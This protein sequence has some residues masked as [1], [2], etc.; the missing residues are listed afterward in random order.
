MSPLKHPLPTERPYKQVQRKSQSNESACLSSY[1]EILISETPEAAN[2]I[3]E[4]GTKFNNEDIIS[5]IAEPSLCAIYEMPITEEIV[6]NSPEQFRLLEEKCA[7]LEK[8]VL[9]L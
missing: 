3:P 7:A 6:N 8:K 5:A 9:D 2:E 1:H 4:I